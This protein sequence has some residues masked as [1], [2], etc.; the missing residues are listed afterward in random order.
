MTAAPPPRDSVLDALGYAVRVLT[1]PDFLWAPVVLYVVL[2][3]PLLATPGITGTPPTIVTQ[4]E[5][6]AY[7]RSFVPMIVGSMVTGIVVGPVL[8]AVMYRLAKQYV[9]GEPPEPFAPG[10]VGLAWRFFLQVI[11]FVVLAVVGTLALILIAVLVQAIA[12]VGLAILVATMGGLIGYVLVVLRVVVAPVLLLEGAGP[13]ESIGKSW[14]LTRGHLG[15]VFRWVIVSGLI[16]GLGAGLI[17]GLIAGLFAAIGQPAV[18]QFLGTLIASPI[19][20][21]GTIVVV[22]LARVLSSPVQAPP[23][24][25]ALPDWMNPSGPTSEPPTAPPGAAG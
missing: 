7:F 6:E 8:S 11:V 21:V 19:G 1:K 5:L 15:R 23:A 24:P 12:G 9:D 18:G 22:L 20:L 16:I 4:A 14:E 10:V 17:S 2:L 3:L 25:P 13:V